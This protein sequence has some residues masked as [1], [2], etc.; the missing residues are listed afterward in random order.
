MAIVGT[1]KLQSYQQMEVG[2][3]IRKILRQYDSSNDI[4]ISGGAKG[5]DTLAVDRAKRLGFSV[6][7]HKPTLEEW[8]Y[9]K[10][11]NL[12]IANE[13]DHLYCITTPVYKIRCYHH[14]TPQDHEK[15]AG[16]WTMKKALELDKKCNILVISQ[17]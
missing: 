13:C 9:Y 6:K 12:L 1:S 10:E 5:V 4:I 14:G 8:K 15:T 2:T 7:I 3:I 17:I 11:R 16:C